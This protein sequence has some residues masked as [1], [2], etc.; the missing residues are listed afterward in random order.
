MGGTPGTVR[1]PIGR[2]PPP[3]RRRPGSA[4]GDDQLAGAAGG[5]TSPVGTI[6][7]S[8]D[9]QPQAHRARQRR[10]TAGDAGVQAHVMPAVGVPLEATFDP[11]DL[12]P[13]RPGHTARLGVVHGVHELQAPQPQ[14]QRPLGQDVRR[15]GRDPLPAVMWQPGGPP[16]VTDQA[17]AATRT[18]QGARPPAP[19]DG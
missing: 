3:A 8:G 7:A 17:C 2:G 6:E 12:E 9:T 1:D 13:S 4:A 15:P 5:V 14:I 11:L 18:A 16:M 19:G 10:L